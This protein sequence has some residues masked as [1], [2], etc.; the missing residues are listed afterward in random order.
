MFSSSVRR[1]VAQPSPFV[2]AVANVS[3]PRMVCTQTLAVKQRRYSS[4]KPSSPA[5]GRGAVVP[6]VAVK[7]EAKKGKKE[8]KKAK[9][10]GLPSVPSTGH[11][12]VKGMC[13]SARVVL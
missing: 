13:I 7:A 2:S 5:D 10:G 11:L 12:Q 8:G 9:K 4:S 3:A 1:A 6:V